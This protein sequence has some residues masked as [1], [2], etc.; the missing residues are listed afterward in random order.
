MA[1]WCFQYGL[2]KT[3]QVF[4]MPLLTRCSSVSTNNCNTSS[5]VHGRCTQ[6][7][8]L[9]EIW[10]AFHHPIHYSFFK[11]G[12]PHSPWFCPAAVNP[13]QP[14]PST[15]ISSLRLNS[16]ILSSAL[17]AAF[18]LELLLSAY[19]RGSYYQALCCQY[20]I[21]HLSSL[22]QDER[23]CWCTVVR[24]CCVCTYCMAV[25]S[26]LVHFEAVCHGILM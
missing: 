22:I 10:R 23:F 20:V 18:V 13:P 7:L 19:Q 11:S 15:I 1:L 17:S 4:N 14:S 5:V 16:K 12:F 6:H 3:A 26:G 25:F 9:C 21:F 2:T 24:R 8:N